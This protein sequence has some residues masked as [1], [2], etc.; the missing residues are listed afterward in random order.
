MS[1]KG[2]PRDCYGLRHILV[3]VASMTPWV[4]LDLEIAIRLGEND[5]GFT[6]G[7]LKYNAETLEMV[8]LMCL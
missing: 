1:S 8:D 7:S 5:L 2:K 3:I 4:Y 6:M